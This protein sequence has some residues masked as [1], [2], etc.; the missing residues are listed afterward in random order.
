MSESL[1]LLIKDA[2]QA[3]NSVMWIARDLGISVDMVARV[4]DQYSEDE[5]DGHG[6]RGWWQPKNGNHLTQTT[7]RT[8]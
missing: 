3:G 4:V 7:K 5:D 1:L 6:Q 2:Y 8:N